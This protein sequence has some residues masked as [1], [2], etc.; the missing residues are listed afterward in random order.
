[1]AILLTFILYTVL[2][3]FIA[4]SYKYIINKVCS[5]KLLYIILLCILLGLFSA[6]RG[7]AGTDTLAYRAIYFGEN[8]S[9]SRGPLYIFFSNLFSSIGLPYEVFLFFIGF[10][11][12]L[13]SFLAMNMEREKID[14]LVAGLVFFFDLYLYSFNVMRQMLAISICLLAVSLYLREEKK[15]GIFLFIV[16]SL[17]HSPAIIYLTIIFFHFIFKKK[18]HKSIAVICVGITLFL[19]LNRNVLFVVMNYLIGNNSH[20]MHYFNAAYVGEMDIISYAIKLL[21]VIVFVIMSSTYLK[22]DKQMRI[23]SILLIIGYILGALDEFYGNEVGRIGYYFSYLRIFLLAY[24][25]CHKLK[26]GKFMIKQN[27]EK[28]TVI[29]YILIV[30]IY[31]IYIAGG[32]NLVPYGLFTI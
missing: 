26:F 5:N 30:Y 25:A 13:F 18:Y 19:V 6:L 2:G 4:V 23:Y 12:A 17:I 32:G 20:Y 21:P 27:W 14:P 7:N 3:T 22:L 9:F 16:A 31:N 8:T 15:K 10:I 1:M 11:T 29:S 28:A 24:F